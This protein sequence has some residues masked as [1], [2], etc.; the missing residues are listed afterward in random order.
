M[1]NEH[2]E[3]DHDYDGIKERDNPLPRWW[4]WTFYG[5][6]FFAVFYFYH[7]EVFRSGASLMEEYTAELSNRSHQK[8]GGGEV[9]AEAM[10]ALAK[11]PSM[12][13]EGKVAFE[14]FCTPCHGANGEGKIGPNLTDPYWLHGGKPDAVYKTIATG[15]AD[16]GMPAWSVTLGEAKTQRVAAFV[17]SIRNTNVPGKPPQ[18]DEYK[19]E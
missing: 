3:L 4:L 15:V 8:A 1:Q 10:V 7:Y 9:S 5:T 13:E 19:G 14:Q 6:V 12:V 16:K 18:G 11:D 2:P 17:V